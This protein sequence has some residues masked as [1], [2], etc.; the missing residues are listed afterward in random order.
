MALFRNDPAAYQQAVRDGL[1]P[2]DVHRAFN[3]AR[4]KTVKNPT[5]LAIVLPRNAV[6]SAI[7][8]MV[9]LS[10]TCWELLM[11]Y[12]RISVGRTCVTS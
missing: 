6:T 5:T 12:S 10:M 7:D 9:V 8:G 2:A 3:W 11:I 1:I 4:D